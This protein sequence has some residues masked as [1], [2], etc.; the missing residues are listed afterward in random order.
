MYIFSHVFV[1]LSKLITYTQANTVI[2]CSRIVFDTEPVGAVN[3]F[4][5]CFIAFR[6]EL[7]DILLN[8]YNEGKHGVLFENKNTK[9]L[10]REIKKTTLFSGVPKNGNINSAREAGIALA[11][12][13]YSIYSLLCG[14]NVEFN[15]DID[16]KLISGIIQNAPRFADAEN[17]L[18]FAL[19]MLSNFCET[20]VIFDGF[21]VTNEVDKLFNYF[22][23]RM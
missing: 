8:Q 16:I 4:E 21:G 23:F 9:T 6:K 19:R 15:T 20:Y 18:R 2:M 22:N 11:Q 13:T 3:N 1:L 14:L 7:K 5:V 17:R 10:M 12:I